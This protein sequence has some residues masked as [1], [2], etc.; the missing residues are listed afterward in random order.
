LEA[1]ANGLPNGLPNVSLNRLESAEQPESQIA[2]HAVKAARTTFRLTTTAALAL[3]GSTHS[4]A[5]QRRRSLT[6]TC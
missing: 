1:V 2:T 4:N 6:A 5:T 3:I